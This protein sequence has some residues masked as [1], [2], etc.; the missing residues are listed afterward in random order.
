MLERSIRHAWKA[1]LYA[2][3]TRVERKSYSG[4]LPVSLAL[5]E[6]CPSDWLLETMENVVLRE[7]PRKVEQIGRTGFLPVDSELQ[8]RFHLG[9]PSSC[10]RR[11]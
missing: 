1:C 3:S 4:P 8:Q 6:L 2:D 10:G 11:D 9:T 5:V 7:P